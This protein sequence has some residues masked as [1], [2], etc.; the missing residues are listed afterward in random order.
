MADILIVS[1]SP[2][3]RAEIRSVLDVKVDVVREMTSGPDAI[4]SC[5]ERLPD[6]VVSDMQV[7][8]MGGMA[9][10]LELRLEESG[11]RLGEVPVLLVVD[12]RP[13][14]F[15]ARRAEAEGWLVKP[16]DPIRLR[17][18]IAALLDDGIY[19]DD[20]Y[21]PATSAAAPA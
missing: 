16:L 17:R 13:D 20:S 18:A 15:L 8:S 3:V 11:G 14:V 5:R 19:E 2:E 1:D 7:G 4:A 21:R 12:R 9:I 6:L 10:C